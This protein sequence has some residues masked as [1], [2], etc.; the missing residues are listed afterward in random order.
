[1]TVEDEEVNP[2]ML[3]GCLALILHFMGKSK[4]ETRQALLVLRDMLQNGYTKD[5][6]VKYY[7]N[8]KFKD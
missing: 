7:Q 1:M 3:K 6:M 4:Y 8:L 2:E 5:D